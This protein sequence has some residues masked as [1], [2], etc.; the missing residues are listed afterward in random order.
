MRC[1]GAVESIVAMSVALLLVIFV[2][3]PFIA[4]GA[5]Q[6]Q[7]D[8][9]RQADVVCNRLYSTFSSVLCSQKDFYQVVQL[10]KTIGS[11]PYDL[12]FLPSA[13]GVIVNY[14]FGRLLCQLPTNRIVNSTNSSDPFVVT[15]NTLKFTN[16]DITVMVDEL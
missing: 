13:R 5:Q 15:S 6:S 10:P 11:H 16:V 3:V 7:I 4:G 14:S 1:Q 12:E 8:T 2:V 9:T